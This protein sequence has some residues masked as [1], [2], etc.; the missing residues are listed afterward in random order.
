MSDIYERG[1]KYRTLF[2]RLS[3]AQTQGLIKV[4]INHPTASSRS[5]SLNNMNDSSSSESTY[6]F[7]YQKMDVKS[8]FQTPPS[9][10]YAD[11]SVRESWDRIRESVLKILFTKLLPTTLENELK[12]DLMRLGRE[13]IVEEAGQN[14][15]NRF[16]SVGPFRYG[17]I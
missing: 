11:P 7:F 1:S 9:A 10:A 2:I 12:R 17:S 5:K 8:I 4:T 16:L 15:A 3:E 13:T 6:D 14:F